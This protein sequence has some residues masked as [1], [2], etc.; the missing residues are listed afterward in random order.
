M[1]LLCSQTPAPQ[2]KISDSA[3]VHLESVYESVLTCD[4]APALSESGHGF[5]RNDSVASFEWYVAEC[6]CTFL[7]L[8]FLVV[9]DCS[10][11][12]KTGSFRFNT[13]SCMWN[14]LKNSFGLRSTS[15]LSRRTPQFHVTCC[16]MLCHLAAPHPRHRNVAIPDLQAMQGGH[17][18]SCRDG[19]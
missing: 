10:S 12:L 4:Y 2:K 1:G 17:C 8:S 18:I 19:A 3:V 14:I 16:A 15:S 5:T 13:C 6:G 9:L 11:R 7:E